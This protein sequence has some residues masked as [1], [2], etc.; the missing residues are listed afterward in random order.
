VVFSICVPLVSEQYGNVTE[1]SVFPGAMAKGWEKLRSSD[2]FPE[3]IFAEDFDSEF[4]RLIE[5]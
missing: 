1:I 3:Y 2:H 4:F 5:F